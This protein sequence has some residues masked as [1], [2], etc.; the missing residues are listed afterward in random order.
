[1]IEFH[2]EYDEQVPIWTVQYFESAMNKEGN[3]FELHT[4]AGMRHYLG[5]GNPKYSHYFDDEIL[6][7]ADDF[8]RKYNLLD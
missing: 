1:M 5:E 2:G 6:K 3:Y 8:L 4:Y 7:I